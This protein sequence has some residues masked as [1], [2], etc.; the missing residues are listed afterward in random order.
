MKRRTVS[1]KAS[2]SS[3]NSSRLNTALPSSVSVGLRQVQ[4]LLGDERQDQLLGDRRDA[5]DGHL[6]Q[7]SLDV[8]FLRVAEAAVREDRLETGVVAGARA[9]ELRRVGLGA[10]RLMLVVQPRAL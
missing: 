4:H 10:A 9:Q 5:R 2:W 7:Q 6:A 1:R 8:V 3:L